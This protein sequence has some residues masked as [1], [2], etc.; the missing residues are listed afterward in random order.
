MT[1]LF[2]YEMNNNNNTNVYINFKQQKVLKY[3]KLSIFF[4]LYNNRFLDSM[5]LLKH[6]YKKVSFIHSISWVD[7][8]LHL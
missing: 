7:T 4:T 2:S 3:S 5:I 8:F 1:I 6:V